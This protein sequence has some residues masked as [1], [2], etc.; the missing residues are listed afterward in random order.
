MW[1][2]RIVAISEIPEALAT[3]AATV[4]VVNRRWK[5]LINDLEAP[6][7]SE[8]YLLYQTLLGHLARGGERRP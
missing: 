3:L 1:R 4:H 6:D 7:A 2:A 8:E 5:Q